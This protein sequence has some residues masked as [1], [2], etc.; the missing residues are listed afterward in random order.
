MSHPM[1]NILP[2]HERRVQAVLALLRENRR[3]PSAR[4]TG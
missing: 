4:N 3:P 1:P 2:K